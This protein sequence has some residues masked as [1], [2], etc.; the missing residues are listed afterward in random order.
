[1]ATTDNAIQYDVKVVDHLMSYLGLT[2]TD[3][4]SL[5]KF[6]QLGLVQRDRAVEMAMAAVGGYTITSIDGQD[7]CDGS[8]AKSVTSNARNNDIKRGAWKNSFNVPG[9]DT[10]TGPLRVIAYNKIKD[11]FHYFYIPYE[12]HCGVK[13]LEI[14]IEQYTS[15]GVAPEFTGEPQRHRKWWNYECDSFEQMASMTDSVH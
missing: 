6:V 2:K 7:F 14:I 13:R 5:R 11:C 10:K 1:M 4:K 3:E 8:D 15:H 12:A 9:T